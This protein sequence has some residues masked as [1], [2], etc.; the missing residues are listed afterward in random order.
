MSNATF[1]GTAILLFVLDMFRSDQYFVVFE[2]I[3]GGEDMERFK[4]NSMEEAVSVLQQVIVSL[5]VAEQSLMFEHRDL[6]WGNVLIKRTKSKKIY[7]KLH[8][9]KICVESAGVVVSI[10]DFTLSRLTKGKPILLWLFKRKTSCVL[11][12]SCLASLACVFI[13][14]LDGIT[15]FCDLSKDPDIFKGKGDYQFEVYRLM[16]KANK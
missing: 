16:K 8:G 6:H 10:I 9:E 11:H 14:F 2:F 4:F 7:Y 5:S 15:V 3:N 13:N 1:K 12:V